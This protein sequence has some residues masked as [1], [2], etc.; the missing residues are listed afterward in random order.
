MFRLRKMSAGRSCE[1]TAPLLYT[2]VRTEK[3]ECRVF[4][5]SHL[6]YATL[7]PGEEGDCL[8]VEAQREEE[9]T[10]IECI[11]YTQR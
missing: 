10:E 7:K 4:Y 11:L 3:C 1:F 9:V 5:C 6:L 8:P 2:A